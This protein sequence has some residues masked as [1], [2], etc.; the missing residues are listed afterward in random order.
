VRIRRLLIAAITILAILSFLY[1]TGTC[2]IYFASVSTDK[3]T[4]SMGERVEVNISNRDLLFSCSCMGG[5]QYSIEYFDQD[6][7]EWVGLTFP[8]HNLPREEQERLCNYTERTEGD[9]QRIGWEDCDVIYMEFDPLSG[10]SQ[11]KTWLTTR[12]ATL[13][14]GEKVTYD[15]PAGLYRAKYGYATKKF[16]V[17]SGGGEN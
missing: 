13:Y 6:L 11:R 9:G 16:T 1:L 8:T 4:Y 3:D 14:C 12:S 17:E 2:R 10:F 15:V 5:P 7:K